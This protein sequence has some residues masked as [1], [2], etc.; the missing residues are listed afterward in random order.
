M[1]IKTPAGAFGAMSGL[2]YKIGHLGKLFFWRYEEWVTSTLDKDVVVAHI[3][4]KK[5]P[6]SLTKGD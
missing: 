1:A 2:Y 3:R 5:S 6:F 4:R